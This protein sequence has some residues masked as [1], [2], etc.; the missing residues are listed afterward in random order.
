MT[1]LCQ[2]IADC[3]QDYR[4]GE[5]EKPSAQ[6]VHR[7]AEQFDAVVRERLLTEMS[8]VLRKTYISKERFQNCLL[9][10]ALS[11]NLAGDNAAQFWKSV[12]F[13]DKQKK[14]RSQRDILELFSGILNKSFGVTSQQCGIQGGPYVYLDDII[15]T[16][17]HVIEDISAWLETTAPN[18]AKVYVV[19]AVVHKN[20]ACFAKKQLTKRAS[21]VRKKIE[22]LWKGIAQP[23]NRLQLLSSSDV[24][25]PAQIPDDPA[26]QAYVQELQTAGYPPKIRSGGSVGSANL[27]SS[28]DGRHLLEQQFLMA[29]AKIRHLRR[30]W[31]R[32]SDHSVFRG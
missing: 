30:T 19:A 9:K 17:S 22:F 8:L 31:P 4:S 10:I 15:F 21:Q 11:K 27:F 20:G 25:S 14:G 23:E 29:G 26:V 18:E 6:H 7:W 3:I 12:N 2:T 24:L 5:V 32:R 1:E 16:G 28:A 13:L